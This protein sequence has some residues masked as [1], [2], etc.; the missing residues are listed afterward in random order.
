MENIN[1]FMED[2]FRDFPVLA[3]ETF[4]SKIENMF[5]QS[6]PY[7]LPNS[8]KLQRFQRDQNPFDDI[9]DIQFDTITLG[10]MSLAS[11]QT[12][13]RCLRCSNFTRTFTPEPYPFL[14]HRLNSRCICGG[15]FVQYTQ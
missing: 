14:V 1:G 9:S 6:F 3:L 10:K 5:P 11:N 12:F 7:L 2:F 8:S 13:S 4:Q 15:L